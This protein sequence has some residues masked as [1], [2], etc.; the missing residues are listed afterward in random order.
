M[1]LAQFIE[2]HDSV[3]SDRPLVVVGGRVRGSFQSDGTIHNAVALFNEYTV[4][5]QIPMCQT[6]HITHLLCS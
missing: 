2:M 3:Y 1:R 6:D 5:R 4:E